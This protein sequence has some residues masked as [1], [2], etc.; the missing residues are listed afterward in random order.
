MYRHGVEALRER[1]DGL[2]YMMPDPNWAPLFRLFPAMLCDKFPLWSRPLPLEAPFPL[3]PGYTAGP[4]V[5]SGE[6]VDRLWRNAARL[7]R[8]SVVR[9]S[10]S[11]PWK[12]GS[13]DYEVLGV[14]RDGKLVGLVASRHKGDRQWLICDLLAA[15]AGGALQATLAAACNLGQERSLTK[16]PGEPITKIAVL[17][18]PAFMPILRDL[19]FTRDAYDFYFVVQALD[20]SLSKK[21][22]SPAEWYLSPND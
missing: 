15:D 21:E 10:R 14:D 9:D 1:G 19:H 22:I 5:P 8:C 17:A 20:S 3:G 12:I 16:G 7:Y 18:T 4:V 2:I 11:L 6:R 13:G